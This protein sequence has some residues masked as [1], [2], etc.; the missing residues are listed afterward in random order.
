VE[1]VVEEPEPSDLA[2]KRRSGRRFR[3][4]SGS[5]SPPI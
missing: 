4:K 1:A 5:L 3:R 2:S